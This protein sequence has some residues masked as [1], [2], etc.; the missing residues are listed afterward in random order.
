[1]TSFD[2]DNEP[3]WFEGSPYCQSVMDHADQN[4]NITE[5]DAEKLLAE[6]GSSPLQVLDEGVHQ[7]K[8]RHAQTLLIHLGY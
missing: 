4:G 2:F 5:A 7:T 3:R 6:H 1:M 8:L